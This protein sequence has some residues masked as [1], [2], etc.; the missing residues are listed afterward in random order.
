MKPNFNQSE[1]VTM[2]IKVVAACSC[3]HKRENFYV[4]E[5]SS[6][7]DISYVCKNCGNTTFNVVFRC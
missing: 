6:H 5:K 1:P 4:A 2:I 7:D 3:C